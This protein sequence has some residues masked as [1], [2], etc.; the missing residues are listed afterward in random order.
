MRERPTGE[1]EAIL[2]AWAKIF[3]RLVMDN[4]RWGASFPALGGRAVGDWPFS[5]PFRKGFDASC[6]LL[7]MSSFTHDTSNSCCHAVY[8]SSPHV[9]PQ[10]PG[11]LALYFWGPGA[12]GKASPGPML[13]A[14]LG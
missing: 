5:L 6:R 9:S 8:T 7:C 10:S 14:Q 11:V 4:T 2:L 1:L 12:H 13:D 3:Q